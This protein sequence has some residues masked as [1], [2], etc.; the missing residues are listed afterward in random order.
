M[1]DVPHVYPGTLEGR[2]LLRRLAVLDDAVIEVLR[3]RI[4]RIW[5]WNLMDDRA[6]DLNDC[7][8]EFYRVDLTSRHLRKEGRA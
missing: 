2:K 4:E 1:R 8:S 5:G 3:G 7:L 6:K